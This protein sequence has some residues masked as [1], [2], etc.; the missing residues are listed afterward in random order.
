MRWDGELASGSVAPGQSLRS[1]LQ[2]R[3]SSPPRWEEVGIFV[4]RAVGSTEGSSGCVGSVDRHTPHPRQPCPSSQPSQTV[5]QPRRYCLRV[6]LRFPLCLWFVL[7]IPGFYQGKF[8][9][10]GEGQLPPCCP[11]CLC[12]FGGTTQGSSELLGP[13]FQHLVPTD[14]HA[15]SLPAR[16][17][18]C[19]RPPG[20]GR[21]AGLEFVAFLLSDSPHL[22][23]Q[24]PLAIF[25]DTLISGG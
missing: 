24:W 6:T 18:P 1:A 12:S 17:R 4:L 8:A 7:R 5:C 11:A 21:E 19:G 25:L 10:P 2:L 15:T 14:P 16:A 23:T 20:P 9:E 13:L 3:A 22:R